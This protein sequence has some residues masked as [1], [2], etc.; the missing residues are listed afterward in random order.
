MVVLLLRCGSMDLRL[1]IS[2][3]LELSPV[4]LLVGVRAREAE[5]EG[6][7]LLRTA[8]ILGQSWAMGWRKEGKQA[9]MMPKLTSTVD[10][11][12]IEG[13]FWLLIVAV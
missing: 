2:R 8:R 4:V 12:A 7:L 11:M 1:I 10:Q 6:S 5:A 9:H 3:Y 13:S